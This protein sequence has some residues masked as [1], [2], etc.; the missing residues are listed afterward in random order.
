MGNI[1]IGWDTDALD[2]KY[3]KIIQNNF[4]QIIAFYLRDKAD[5]NV[6]RAH[7][8]ICLLTETDM[9]PSIICL[10]YLTEIHLVDD[11]LWQLTRERWM[12]I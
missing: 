12:D 6:T 10:S 9:A 7:N 3:D 1:F 8:L 4:Q 2:V 5:K 11:G